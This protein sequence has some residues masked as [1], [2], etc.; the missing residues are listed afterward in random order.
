MNFAYFSMNILKNISNNGT[1]WLLDVEF[2]QILVNCCVEW[3]YDD[4]IK[5]TQFYFN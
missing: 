3:P 5:Q 2:T 4:Q 1:E